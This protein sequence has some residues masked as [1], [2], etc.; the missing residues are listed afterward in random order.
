MLLKVEA[1]HPRDYITNLCPLFQ[2]QLP[3]NISGKYV[4]LVLL[5]SPIF[6]RPPYCCGYAEMLPQLK[7]RSCEFGM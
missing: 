4:S 1:H 6:E 7:Q 2:Y 3:Y 5:P